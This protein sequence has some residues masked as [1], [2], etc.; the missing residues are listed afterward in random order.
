M[1]WA[2]QIPDGRSVHS[3]RIGVAFSTLQAVAPGARPRYDT[4][5]KVL[6]RLG[7]KL[8]VTA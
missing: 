8:S 6:Q 5:L 2:T 1:S 7:A 4:V 3:G